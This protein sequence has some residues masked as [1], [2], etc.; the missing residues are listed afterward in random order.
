MNEKYKSKLVELEERIEE[1]ESEAFID[2]ML[3]EALAKLENEKSDKPYFADAK[4]GDKVWDLV[5][6]EG[7]I[8]DV[9]NCLIC[10]VFPMFMKNYYIS[11]KEL[12]SDPIQRL[13]YYNRRPIIIE[14][15]NQSLLT[16]DELIKITNIAGR[17]QYSEWINLV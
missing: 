13:F 16:T 4:V 10:V 8:T 5:Y 6:G 12:H 15:D 2:S 1:L 9:D 11:G 17:Q 3:N 7:E 14:R